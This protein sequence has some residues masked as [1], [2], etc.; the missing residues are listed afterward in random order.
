MPATLCVAVTAQLA[1][2]L[3]SA[4]VAVI[5]AV[6]G[7]TAVTMPVVR[8]TVA[9]LELPLDQVMA[10]FVAFAGESVADK[11]PVAPTLRARLVELRLTLVTDTLDIVSE[12]VAVL[13]PSAVVAVI[14]ALPAAVP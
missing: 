3:P 5:V 7:P 14:A 4:V 2:W 11:L 13:P 1:V 6:P 12:H 8:P 9:T 10:L